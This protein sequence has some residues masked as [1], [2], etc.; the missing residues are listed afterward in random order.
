MTREDALRG[1]ETG[2]WG[3]AL[4]A[5]A[6]GESTP[7]LIAEFDETG[8]ILYLSPN[9]REI[10]GHP[11]ECPLEFDWL[12]TVHPDD[13]GAMRAALEQ[14]AAGDSLR[15]LFRARPAGGGWRWFECFLASVWNASGELRPL[16]IRRHRNTEG[17]HRI[18]SVGRDVS[19]GIA[20]EQALREEQRRAQHLA[21]CQ[22]DRLEVERA[23]V[24]REIH[25]E[26]GQGLTGLRLQ[27]S[28]G[29]EG[30]GSDRSQRDVMLAQIDQLIE[31][32]R[33]IGGRMLPPSL[34]E[35]GLVAAIESQAR[36]LADAAGWKLR[37]ELTPSETGLDSRQEAAVFRVAQECLTNIARHA[38]ASE[39][40][41]R[42][43][44]VDDHL[45]LSVS[46]DGRGV[47]QER[48]RSPRSS[49]IGGMRARAAALG[50]ALTID[51]NPGSGTVVRLE[52]PAP[53]LRTGRIGAR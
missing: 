8:H 44:V 26:F 21:T 24:A 32:V 33:R 51:G 22:E 3:D 27:L 40:E 9:H 1:V 41:V 23:R 45:R 31:A 13:R 34:E 46:D 11:P 15:V 2:L 12:R 14:S 18:L 4:R 47:S 37:T 29:S 52:V 50:A 5:R 39:V 38:D 17:E 19:E 28:S 10:V 30:S 7:Y 20:L 25:D 36:S 53:R 42:L 43:E 35:F 16:G 49:G 48:V 6:I